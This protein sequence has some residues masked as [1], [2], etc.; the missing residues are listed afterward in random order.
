M[1]LVSIQIFGLLEIF[2]FFFLKTGVVLMFIK[3]KKKKKAI[4]HILNAQ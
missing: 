3:K 1:H 4:S 2:K